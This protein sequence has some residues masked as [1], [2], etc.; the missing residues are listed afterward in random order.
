M[1]TAHLAF[2]TTKLQPL[3]T[4]TA[5]KNLIRDCLVS[6]L[7]ML[8]TA[9]LTPCLTTGWHCSE[10]IEGRE[11]R[12]GAQ[13][14]RPCRDEGSPSCE[15][16]CCSTHVDTK[17]PI[18]TVRQLSCQPAAFACASGAPHAD[19]G[20]TA[21]VRS[22]S[23]KSTSCRASSE[24]TLSEHV[25]PVADAAAVTSRTPRAAAITDGISGLRR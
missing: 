18:E 22:R 13:A 1:L 19:F 23:S 3:V 14:R 8:I 5:G 25:L 6:V 15:W 11:Q 20:R 16:R 17:S 10:R 4:E 12:V 24:S 9:L 21:A 2:T 7:R